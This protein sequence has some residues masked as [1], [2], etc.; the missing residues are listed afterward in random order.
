MKGFVKPFG[1]C[2]FGCGVAVGGC[3]LGTGLGVLDLGRRKTDSGGDSYIR[4][5]GICT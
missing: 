4:Y 2:G 5:P 1:A 3:G